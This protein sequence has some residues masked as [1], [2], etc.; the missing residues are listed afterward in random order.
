MKTF[1]TLLLLTLSVGC[2]APEAG[3]C[4]PDAPVVACGTHAETSFLASPPPAGSDVAVGIVLDMYD[5]HEPPPTVY[6]YDGSR[7]NCPDAPWE[8]M[9]VGMAGC[10]DGQYFPDTNEIIASDWGGKY[11][12]HVLSL[13]HELCHWWALKTTGD[14]D[15]GHTGLCKPEG[16][17]GIIDAADY[18]LLAKGY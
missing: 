13:A 5:Y 12:I 7:L 4:M 14:G 9:I 15:A 17:G 18:A 3:P 6:W 16:Q 1:I 2:A 8:F 11:P 10:A